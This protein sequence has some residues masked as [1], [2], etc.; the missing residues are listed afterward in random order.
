[1]ELEECKKK[2]SVY[3]SV[4]RHQC[5]SFLD[6]C[7][8]I[9]DDTCKVQEKIVGR[10]I[11]LVQGSSIDISKIQSYVKADIEERTKAMG[12]MTE[13]LMQ[14]CIPY[15]QRYLLYMAENGVRECQVQQLTQKMKQDPNREELGNVLQQFTADEAEVMQ[16]QENRTFLLKSALT[17]RK[18]VQKFLMYQRKI[19]EAATGLNMFMIENLMPRVPFRTFTNYMKKVQ[20]V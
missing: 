10:I 19:Q 17:L 9:K 8:R 2:L 15:S 7:Q 4:E 12:I 13:T 11:D 6:F 18:N 14:V 1:M 3:E 20:Q 16:V 5:K